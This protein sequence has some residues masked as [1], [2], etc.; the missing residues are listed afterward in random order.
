MGGTWYFKFW[1]W[2]VAGGSMMV[3]LGICSLIGLTY[4]IERLL[5]LKKIKGR[6]SA[7]QLIE[8]I[9]SIFAENKN[10]QDALEKS[11]EY[12]NTI[13]SPL[14][15]I[16]KEGLIR[17]IGDL[18]TNVSSDKYVD[19][20]KSA[21]QDAGQKELP[22]FEANLN[23][24]ETVSKIAPLLGLLGTIMGMIQAFNVIACN[25]AGVRPDQLAGGISQ[26]LITTEAGLMIAIPVIVFYTIIRKQIDNYI[27]DIEVS[28][29]DLIDTLL[30]RGKK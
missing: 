24:L 12:C 22:A 18:N 15:G 30:I 7:D 29:V 4:I 14:T 5:F 13:K 17:H 20:I 21:I 16:L 27:T 8:K 2:C 10:K 23:I 9:K 19:E 28:T 6:I 1:G 11:I 26:A 25:P 3:P